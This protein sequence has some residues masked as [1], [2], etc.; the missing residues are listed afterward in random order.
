MPTD[1]NKIRD[2]NIREYG[3]GTRHLSFLGRL[4]TDRTHFIF[5]LLQN[6]EDAGASKVLFQLFK[7]K[8]EVRHDGR[9]FNEKDV[10]GICG[11]GEGTKAEDLNQIGKF[12]IGFKSVYA[13]TTTPEIYSGDESFKIE[14][15]VRPYAV[16][17][18]YIGDSWT[19]L[20]VFPFNKEDVEPV[21]ACTEISTR[22]R[23]LNAR[24]LLFLRKI[25]EIEYRLPD[26]M[27]GVY[28]RDE[29]KRGGA[30]VVT[31]IGQNNGEEE[32][33]SWL[34]FEHPVDVP[35]PSDDG[36][37]QVPVEVGFRLQ[38]NE[39]EQRDEVVRIKDSTLVVFFPTEK[40]TRLGFLIQGPY[41][42]TP[43]RDNI[44]KEDDWNATLVNETSCLMA[45]VLPL[46]KDLGL[47][48]VSLLEALPIRADDFPE[49]GMFY[50][51]FD[52]VRN[53]LLTQD[54]LPADDGSFVSARNAKLA[55]ADW[56]RKL[57]RQDQLKL[58]FQKELKWIHADITERGRH[59]VWKY[60]REELKIEEV[61]PDGFA[62]KVDH[63]FFNDQSDQWM[64]GFYAQL[65][66]QKALWKKG[67]G[68][69][70]D[71]DGPLRKK[72]FLRLQDGSHVRPFDDDDK[73]NAYLP[74]KTP[75]DSQLP[76]VKA[77]IA[78]HNE[79][80]RFL[81]SDLKIPEFDIVAEVIEHVLPKYTSPNPPQTDEH[82]RD[83][84]KIVEA[85]QTDSQEKQKRLK[86][87]LK[88][89]PFI[90]SRSSISGDEIYRKPDALYFQ[91]ASLEMYFSGNSDVGFIGVIYK[92]KEAALK[93]FA[94]LGVRYGVRID[95][96]KPDYQGC[97]R[98]RD[99][100]GWHER[101]LFGFD[102]D[103]KV[104][105][106]WCALS[107]PTPEKSLFI[108]NEIV[109]PN[110][111]C[112]RGTIEKSS[113]QTY[114]NSRKEERISES[115]GRL[116]ME[117]KWLPGADGQF[118]R[119]DEISLDQLP[120]GFERNEKVADLLGMKKDIVARLAEEAGVNLETIELA[121]ELERNP[122]I[123]KSVQE[124]M[125]RKKGF[126]F[127]NQEVVDPERR[128]RRILEELQV[129][130]DK[131][132]EPRTRS[133]RVSEATQFVRTWL[134][135]QYKNENGQ[136]GCQICKKEMP[137]KKL[138]GEYYFEA[139]EVFTKDI[140]RKEHE[141]LFLALCPLCA[142][143][144]KELVK[145]DKAAMSDF[146]EALLN[147]DSLEAP[148]RLGDL[149]TSI[150]FVETHLFD[151]KTILKGNGIE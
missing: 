72:P 37:R 16:Q 41:K 27:S 97:I 80:R 15:Y 34:I 35:N 138:D 87:A 115:F 22:L 62:R 43:A 48:S 79:V 73:P 128:K 14:Y 133:V 104:E 75:V 117:S 8:L 18:Q 31:V 126:E 39:K 11:V 13:Y 121:R 109:L 44:P 21:V 119:P 12:G 42:T 40:E 101:G 50:P 51:I 9:L 19:T 58:L 46:L 2:D 136:I 149:V 137:F 6:A 93:M 32:S 147:T 52:A 66:N 150:R 33:E 5:E 116:L 83:I 89:T 122:D 28:L 129:S 25:K 95:K 131:Q 88:E 112:I 53:A 65:P 36:P 123:L 56:L 118:Y 69:Y 99:Y 78:S 113:R 30:R 94:S 64:I 132:Y 102:P 76:T 105:G 135:N 54:L 141:A 139:V 57:L 61:T 81:V 82:L 100:H 110:A 60:L 86:D 91:D 26:G 84:E 127:R 96:R 70:W 124:Q 10:R 59:E 1:Y 67:S 20:F 125:K 71:A 74:A 29:T 3:Q 98:L 108:W 146:R 103:I 145:K 17:K 140:F 144:Y 85:F 4:Y 68:N 151:I 38:K 45:D 143:M 55:S 92:D 77:E 106:L 90:L 130:P 107:S 7:D 148:L 111:N 142:A 47:L 120:E 134:Q 63:A 114:E 49:D 23:K 24:T